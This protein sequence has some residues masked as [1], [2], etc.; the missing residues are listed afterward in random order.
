VKALIVHWT[1]IPK[2]RFQGPSCP[3]KILLMTCLGT[4]MSY[5][6]I[7]LIP[8]GIFAYHILASKVSDEKYTYNLIKDTLYVQVVSLLML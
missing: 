7:L 1:D 2:G 8:K 5:S 3:V 6:V 4:M